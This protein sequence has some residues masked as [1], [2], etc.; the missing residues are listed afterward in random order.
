VQPIGA[1]RTQAV[2]FVEGGDREDGDREGANRGG[3]DRDSLSFG[4]AEL[5]HDFNSS[6]E[7]KVRNLGRTP[8]AF[9]VTA[10]PAGGAPHT[11]SFDRT[12]IFLDP[13]DDASLDVKLKVPAASVGSTHERPR[14][15]RLPRGRGVVTLT[16]TG[17]SMNGGASLRVPYYLVPRV[18]SNLLSAFAG[19]PAGPSRPSSNV[20]LTNFG[21]RLPGTPTSTPGACEEHGRESSSS[22][23]APSACKRIRSR[24]RTAF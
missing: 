6:L 24:R 13:R 2:A 10:T 19:R 17:T 8:I 4:F 12:T 14:Q 9:K 1:T 5:L 23:P 18:R 22:T 20:K 15:H 11:V 7:L 3:R 16:P 21:A